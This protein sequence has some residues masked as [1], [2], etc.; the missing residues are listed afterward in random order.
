MILGAGNMVLAAIE[1]FERNKNVVYG[2]L[3]DRKEMEGKEF[4]D[5]AVLS[6]TND[7][8]YLKLLGKK[9]EAF[10]STDDVALRKDWVNML[11][12]NFKIMP[13][14]AVHQDCIIS[15]HAHIGHGNFLDQGVRITAG[16][17]IGSHSIVHAGVIVGHGS[18][19]KDF[20]QLGQGSSIG[21]EVKIGEGVFIGAGA[22]IV[23]GLSISD[24]ARIGAG[25]VVVEDV[26]KGVTVFG[27]PAKKV[28]V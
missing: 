12:K 28:Q 11:K 22:V 7:E 27:N 2:I 18:V 24:N 21:S 8:D 26:K 3:D 6:D 13:V 10:I 16:A 23:N 19:I 1:I 20:V 5:I 9:C 17:E 15:D 4:G 25:S 14:N